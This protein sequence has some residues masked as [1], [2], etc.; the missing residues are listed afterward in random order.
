MSGVITATTQPGFDELAARLASQA[1]A[2]AEAATAQTALQSRNDP[3]RWRQ[4]DLLWP[5]FTK[6]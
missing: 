5:Q 4:A 6:G 1:K 2:L 3:T